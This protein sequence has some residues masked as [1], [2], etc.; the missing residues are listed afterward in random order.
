MCLVGATFYDDLTDPVTLEV[1]ESVRQFSR[2]QLSMVEKQLMTASR[3]EPASK[4]QTG[5]RFELVG[6]FRRGKH[7]GHD[8]DFLLGHRGGLE[9]ELLGAFLDR[10]RSLNLLISDV[11]ENGSST[12][13]RRVVAPKATGL[14]SKNDRKKK[15]DDY[16]KSLTI[17]KVPT[18]PRTARRC[19]MVGTRHENAFILLLGLP[20][21]DSP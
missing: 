8:V 7:A 19:Q 9:N 14:E 1:A 21:L 3:D 18:S 20:F 4:Q 6:G 2:Q 5:I 17:L 15:T 10:L 13:A 11:V 12:V 16:K